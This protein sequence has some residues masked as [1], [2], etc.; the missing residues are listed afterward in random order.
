[1][2][3]RVG[4][5]FTKLVA[6]G[7]LAAMLASCSPVI[8][9]HGYAPVDEELAGVRAGQ[10]TRGSVRR[11]IGRPSGTGIFTEDGWFYASS[12]VEHFAFYEPEVIDRRVVAIIFDERDI[13][14]SVNTYGL[15]DGKIIDLETDTTPTFGRELTILEQAFGNLGVITDD[16]IDN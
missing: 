5:I 9:L 13:V 6:G 2:R 8:R 16:L 10:D 1:M 14:Q 4:P 12:R 15:E 7:A 3:S 11:K